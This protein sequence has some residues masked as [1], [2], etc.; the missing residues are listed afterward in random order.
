M[1]RPA[2]AKVNIHQASERTVE[3][4]H[5]FW[6]DLASTST[7]AST[8]CVALCEI[9]C[10]DQVIDARRALGLWHT[11]AYPGPSAWTPPSVG[12]AS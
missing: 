1:R 10:L 6:V 8:R 3:D 5:A 9:T 11:G 4:A 7:C 12:G 2:S